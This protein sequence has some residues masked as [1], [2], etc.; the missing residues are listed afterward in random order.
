MQRK[1]ELSSG[2]FWR[3][4]NIIL[5]ALVYFTNRMKFFSVITILGH[6]CSWVFLN[7]M[8]RPKVIPDYLL[9]FPEFRSGVRRYLRCARSW[10]LIL[11]WWTFLLNAIFAARWNMEA[12]LQ[13]E[14]GD[15]LCGYHMNW[16]SSCLK[17]AKGRVERSHGDSFLTKHDCIKMNLGFIS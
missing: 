7:A 3:Y 11:I 6:L 17:C 5:F 16:Y 8:T 2:N 10:L 12:E 13:I 15:L 1:H 14:S 4:W 9:S